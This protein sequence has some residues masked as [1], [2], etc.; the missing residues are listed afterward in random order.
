MARPLS[1][2]LMMT[3][4]DR[5]FTWTASDTEQPG[6]LAALEKDG[7]RMLANIRS[8]FPPTGETRRDVIDS[9]TALGKRRG[10]PVSIVT[11][12]G[13]AVA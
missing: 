5:L 6:T 8:G 1:P 7:Q 9:A 13:K 3:I 4:G 12:G 2:A 11:T 10:E